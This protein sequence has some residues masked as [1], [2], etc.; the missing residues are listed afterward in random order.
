MK[1]TRILVSG[2]HAASSSSNPF[3]SSMELTEHTPP[4]HQF[5]FLLQFEN[6]AKANRWTEN[7]TCTVLFKF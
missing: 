6:C 3:L 1:L 2:E 4:T 7:E 5:D